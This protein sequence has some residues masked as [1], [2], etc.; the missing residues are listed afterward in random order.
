MP[1]MRV[2]DI[3]KD[4]KT[5]LLAPYLGDFNDFPIIGD[6]I[7]VNN[8]DWLQKNWKQIEG[9]NLLKENDSKSMISKIVSLAS[10]IKPEDFNETQMR[11]NITVLKALDKN[12]IKNIDIKKLMQSEFI[13]DLVGNI[14]VGRLSEQ[15]AKVLADNAIKI[16]NQDKA[17]AVA[18]YMN[19]MSGT[20]LKLTSKSERLKNFMDLDFHQMKAANTVLEAYSRDSELLDRDSY[21]VITKSAS[22][23][24]APG[25]ADSLA[26]TVRLLADNNMKLAPKRLEQ[27]ISDGNLN[28]VNQLL[29]TLK[30]I[31]PDKLG[32]ERASIVLDNAKSLNPDKMAP[33]ADCVKKINGQIPLT[34]KNIR[35]P[36]TDKKISLNSI[37]GKG[38]NSNLATLMNMNQDQLKSA[39][40]LLGSM[41]KVTQQRFDAVKTVC[42]KT[43]P[44]NAKAL[45]TCL[46]QLESAKI[47]ISPNMGKLAA[48]NE[49]KLSALAKTMGQM[50]KGD[51]TDKRFNVLMKNVD[52][53]DSPEKGEAL[54]Q[55]IKAM[56]GS[57]LSLSDSNN[58]LQTM[59]SKSPTEISQATHLIKY[60]NTLSQGALA[61]SGLTS[62][63]YDSIVNNIKGMSTAEINGVGQTVEAMNKVGLYVGHKDLNHIMKTNPAECGTLI[64]HL[65]KDGNGRGRERVET[66]INNADQ[67]DKDKMDVLKNCITTLEANKVPLTRND[68][69]KTLMSMDKGELEKLHG[70]LNK[71]DDHVAPKEAFQA[72]GSQL[73]KLRG[74]KLD[75][76]SDK[77]NGLLDTDKPLIAG[78][79]DRLKGKDNPIDVAIKEAQN[80]RNVE[81]EIV[82]AQSMEQLHQE[83]AVEVVELKQGVEEAHKIVQADREALEEKT[84]DLPELMQPSV[85][86]DADR[87]DALNTHQTASTETTKTSATVHE[88]HTGPKQ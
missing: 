15:R 28:E 51:L 48:L 18:Q 34:D 68:T 71:M 55:Y 67:L 49:S 77:V 64:S 42:Q 58:R 24:A 82:D 14:D 61:T 47:P 6:E 81:R 9:M 32:A 21:D 44:I 80:I 37:F 29:T 59:M 83:E 69:L 35:F 65:M 76:L 10:S 20:D 74:A 85:P 70:M 88:Q 26:K 52:K 50:D 79:M 84:D 41:D 19:N 56:S 66:I 60:I 38:S 62:S 31:R 27:T 13:G 22:K 25:A 3:K 39:S 4:P 17:K 73:P 72:I 2:R 78:T 87:L 1:K 45:G 11:N 86:N 5:Q 75:A 53:L 30:E 16:D 63:K 7:E 43:P 12:K 54:G 23:L 36:L 57:G 46:E 33:L 8:K 40:V